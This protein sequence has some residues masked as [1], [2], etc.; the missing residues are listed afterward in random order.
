MKWQDIFDQRIKEIWDLIK[1]LI[2]EHHE[3]LVPPFL[4]CAW[5]P[6][7]WAMSQHPPVACLLAGFTNPSHGFEFKLDA[8]SMW[9]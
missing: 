4:K 5:V 1:H 2:D 9:C 3:Y 8:S 6:F 7:P